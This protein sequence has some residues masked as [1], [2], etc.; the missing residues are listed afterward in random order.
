WYRKL[1][2]LADQLKECCQALMV[3][4]SDMSINEMMVRFVGQLFHTIQIPGK[5]VPLR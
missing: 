3:P 4:A 5:S 1:L 2:P